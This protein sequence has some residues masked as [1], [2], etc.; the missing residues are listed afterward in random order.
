MGVFPENWTESIVLPLFK[1]GDV[2][3]PGNYR[4]ISLSDI[5]SK[6]YSSIINSRIQEW[7]S[8]NDITGEYQAGFKKGYSTIDHLFTRMACVQKQFNAQSNRKLYV[9]FIDF[10]KAFDSI[11][12][13]LLWPILLKNGI[14][15]KLFRCIK[16]MYSNVK[17]RVRSGDKLTDYI[18]CTAGVKQGDISSPILFTLFINELALEILNNGRHG[19][20]FSL[21]MFELFVLLLADDVVLLSETITGLQSQLNSLQRAASTLK[22]KVNMNKSNIIVFRKGGYLGARERWLYD[23][24]KMPV[25]N[26][27]KYLGIYFSTRLSFVAACKDLASRA[28][29]GLIFVMRKL[30]EL[31]NASVELFFKIFDLQIQPIMQYG[32]EIWGLQQAAQQCEKVHLF[33][34]KKFL[35]VNLRTP[36]DLVYGE[37]DRYPV[38]INSTINC[39]RYWIKSVS[40]THLTL[41]TIA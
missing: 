22:L 21:E 5:S 11:N 12:R 31:D 24:I 28:K 26:I 19:V 33:A 36:N 13:H 9:A 16:S 2:N 3:H 18:N 30:R 23:G 25:V 27:Y 8:E 40:Y 15:G 7:V 41:P 20:H 32:S 1:K 34:I 6:I 17:A 38:T 35:R 14:H 4:G 37:L 39:I 10:E 29:Q